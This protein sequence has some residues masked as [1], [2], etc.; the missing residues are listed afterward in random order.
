MAA[1]AGLLL[2]PA[3]LGLLA[4]LGVLPSAVLAAAGIPCLAL[5]F[6][7]PIT[8]C[9]APGDTSP[10]THLLVALLLSPVAATAVYLAAAAMLG[11]D[12]AMV[13][14][15]AAALAIT[16][17]LLTRRGRQALGNVRFPILERGELALLLIAIAV[18]GLV[19]F[20]IL[21]GNAPR[22]SYHGLLH[23]AVLS[24]VARG[25][26]PENPWLA[27]TGIGYYWFY[28][29]MG[30]LISRTF[31]LAPTHALALLNVWAAFT[32]SLSVGLIA[33]ALCRGTR[34]VL[35]SVALAIC[36]LNVF[37]G[38]WWLV[39]GARW[40]EP[41]NSV[42]L[43]RLMAV[44][45]PPLGS[46]GARLWDTRLAFGM[47]KFG[48]ITSYSASL[49]LICGAWV[50]ASRAFLKPAPGWP[51]LCGLLHGAA[52]LVNPVLAAGSVAAT[53][54]ATLLR[55]GNQRLRMVLSLAGWSLPGIA[56]VVI[57]G[58]QLAGEPLVS[59]AFDWRKLGSTVGPIGA[60]LPLAIL[61]VVKLS[62]PG[63]A[64]ES[65]SGK[66][67]VVTLLACAAVLPLLVHPFVQLPVGNEYKL[68]RLA[69]LPLGILAGV[70]A[71]IA[72]TARGPR[73]VLSALWLGIVIVGSIGSN[74]LGVRSYLAF[75]RLN[76]AVV[77]RPGSLTPAASP[78]GSRADL[79]SRSFAWIRRFAVTLNSEPIL[80]LNVVRES[81]LYGSG[82]ARSRVDREL[83]GNE[84]AAFSGV[85]LWCDLGTYMVNRHPQWTHRLDGLRTLYDS[86]VWDETLGRE[87]R[88]SG[89]PILVLVEQE[90]RARNPRLEKKLLE[91]GF[92]LVHG[93]GS[94]RI[95]AMPRD[96]ASAAGGNNR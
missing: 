24:A 12:R 36:G 6:A 21:Q 2:L 57:A 10:L 74:V 51:A 32:M 65:R 56:M 23:S 64:S 94:T 35:L 28:H 38:W 29:G 40:M 5:G 4:S 46:G 17:S 84:A 49:A 27:G 43:M 71:M 81:P 20:F 42:D 62:G 50:A 83:Q 14:V 92:G 91:H 15:F 80:V 86:P 37:G 90:D 67:C 96:V 31:A 25:V 26:P 7:L 60:L 47:A 66:R 1:A 73:R 76:L 33:S 3:L 87:L 44:Q 58:R 85:S 63:A 16:A 11:A 22:V 39:S 30:V 89:R 45:V 55:G 75:S 48:N 79:M 19:A 13:A 77:E 68:V 88:E 61:A 93:E 70:G 59:V 54:V 8:L 9:L 53:G 72:L 78:A 18:A 34:W 52:L 69:A 82:S 41:R 95:F